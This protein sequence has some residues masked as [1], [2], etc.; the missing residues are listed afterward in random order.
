MGGQARPILTRMCRRIDKSWV[1]LRS[2]E[3]REHD[4]CADL[5]R[6]ADGSSGFEE[7]R[8]DVEDAGAWTPLRTRCVR[9]RRA[10]SAHAGAGRRA[11]TIGSTIDVPAATNIA[12]ILRLQSKIENGFRR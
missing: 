12:T 4:R 9:Q 7:F 11:L 8:R 6:R 5:F 2:I 3:N 10:E 1:V